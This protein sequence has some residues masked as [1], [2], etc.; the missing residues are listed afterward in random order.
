M[1]LKPISMLR[2]STGGGGGPFSPRYIDG[3]FVTGGETNFTHTL[4][5]A[6]TGLTTGN[7]LLVMVHWY[8]DSTGTVTSVGLVGDTAITTPALTQNPGAGAHSISWYLVPVTA[9]PGDLQIITGGGADTVIPSVEI[10]E[11]DPAWT[12]Q[13]N[14]AVFGGDT[15]ITAN[16]TDVD[17]G[18]TVGYSWAVTGTQ[19]IGG[20]TEPTADADGNAYAA[21]AGGFGD[22]ATVGSAIGT[23]ANARAIVSGVAAD[24]VRLAA[25]P[26]WA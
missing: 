14:D 5:F 10:F 9:S 1:L 20:V 2:A 22:R 24:T 26:V 8:T 11:I 18:L 25:G 23:G 3:L 12:L 21:G 7:D 4:A 6:K 17:G 13:N 15:S 19:V 16:V